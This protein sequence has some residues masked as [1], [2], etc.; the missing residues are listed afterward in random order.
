MT[1][2]L[3]VQQV[4][5]ALHD[6]LCRYIEA[7][8][9]VRDT[10]VIEERRALLR[11]QGTI[12]QRPY[13]ETT[14]SYEL[15]SSYEQLDLPAPVG[16]W[17]AE[18]ASWSPAIGVFARPFKHQAEAL[19]AALRD[20]RDLVVATGTGS[21]KTE[22]FLHTILG[23]LVL[24]GAHRTASWARPGVRALLLYPMNA[25]VSD[26]LTR[27]RRLFGDERLAAVFRERTGR[28]PRF[29]M[30][31]SRTPY[32]GVRTSE[33]DR[34]LVAPV[35][36]YYRDLLHGKPL[37]SGEDQVA[38]ET[39]A[40]E[41]HQRG[42]WPAK[43]ID[44]FLGKAGGR[45]EDRLVTHPDDRELLTRHEQHKETP[46]LLITNHSMLEYML[47]RPIERSLFRQTRAWLA[48][49]RAAKLNVVLDEAHLYRGVA[50]AEIGLLLRRLFARLE[51]PRSRVRVILT[52]ASLGDRPEDRAAIERFAREL[53]G[54]P[55]D[56]PTPFVQVSSSAVPR[57]MARVGTSAEAAAF[58]RLDLSGFFQHATSLDAAASAV[59][60]VAA[61]LGWPPPP[62]PRATMT[63][64]AD[65]SLRGYLF[66]HLERT[67][68]LQQLLTLTAGHARPFDGLG[69]LCFPGVDLDVGLRAVTAMVALGTYAHDGKRPLMPARA[70]CFF[71]GLP[72][73]H[74]CIDP[75]CGQRRHQPRDGRPSAVGRLYTEPRTHCDCRSRARVYELYAHRDCGALF[76]RVFG[77]GPTPDFYW[78][79]RGGVVERHAAPFDEHL[80]LLDDPHHRL[81]AL[82]EPIWLELPTG[83]VRLTPPSTEQADLYRQVWRARSGVP[84][85]LLRIERRDLQQR[86]GRPGERGT[87]ALVR[88]P[89]CTRQT[90]YKILDL[91]TKGEQPFANVVRTQL[92]LQPLVRAIDAAYP[93]GGRKVLLFSDGR[94]K[95]ARLARDLPREVEFDS[96][97]QALALATRR[98]TSL[99][100][101]PTLGDALY[102]AFVSVCADNLLYFFDQEDNSQRHLL[103]DIAAYRARY[104]GDLAILLEE[105]EGVTPPGRFRQAVLR[106][107]ADPYYS[108][109]AACCAIVEPSAAASRALGRELVTGSAA[110]TKE[111]IDALLSPSVT[112]W[113]QWLLDRGAFDPAISEAARFAVNPYFFAVDR[114]HRAQDVERILEAHGRLSPNQIGHWREASY[115]ILTREDEAGHP[116]LTPAQLTLR[117]AI[118]E[119]W[120]QCLTCGLTQHTTL[121]GRCMECGADTL[122]PRQ[123]D[124]AYMT[125]RHDYIRLPLRAVLNGARPL[126]MTA[127]EH[128]AQLSQRDGGEVY[129][130][131]EAYELRF[132]DV[133]LDATTP[134]VDVLSCTTTM[135]VGIDIGSLTAVG[136]RNVPPQREHYQQRA[137]RSGRRGS[138]VSTVVTYADDSA[139]D[140]FYYANPAPMI[141][142]P[143]RA[144]TLE[145]ANPRLA[146]R[147]VHAFLIQTF[148]HETLDRLGQVDEAHI[149]AERATLMSALGETRPFLDGRDDFS[150]PAFEA[151][152]ATMIG[153]GADGP[154][155]PVLLT[156]LPD[157]MC[158]GPAAEVVAAEK[159]QFIA[160]TTTGLLEAL[161]SRAARLPALPP[162]PPEGQ[163]PLEDPA[164]LLLDHLFDAGVLPTYAFPTN[165]ATFWIYGRD[166]GRLVV[167]EAPQQDKH[168]AL[169]EYAPG[170]LLV[171]DKKSYRVGGLAAPDLLALEPGGALLGAD[172]PAYVWCPVCT[173]VDVRADCQRPLEPCPVCR[174]GLSQ[175]TLVD[176]PG[177]Y[178]EG[179]RPLRE[180]DSAQAISVASEAQLPAPTH[181]MQLAWE[182]GP[183]RNLQVAIAP[184]QELVLANKGPGEQGFALCERCGAIWPEPD[185]P[186]L[187]RHRRPH[188]L[189]YLHRQA[190][191]DH[192]CDGPLA[193]DPIFL[194]FRFR[195][196]CL[197]LQAP[198]RPP[199]GYVPGGEPWLRDAA[200]TV[201]QALALAA[202]R[203][204]DV[205][206]RELA[207]GVRFVQPLPTMPADAR[208]AI[209]WFLYDTASGGAGY[210]A[211][212]GAVL[213]EVLNAAELLL[214]SC[215][216]DC[217]RSCT[218]CLRHYGNRFW[219]E[220]LDRHIAGQLLA[221]VRRDKA[222]EIESAER[223]AERLA[224]LNQYLTLEGWQVR[225]CIETAGLVVPLRA[226]RNGT[227]VLIGTLPALLDP[228]T[229]RE[230]HPAR[231][232]ARDSGAMDVLLCDYV[233]ARDL[234]TAAQNL[235]RRVQ[236]PV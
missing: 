201:A 30:Y 210:A 37:E 118:D 73:L 179:G 3:G 66:Q 93:N 188:P 57:P 197:L 185:R 71:R 206:P 70:H 43:D 121:A 115:R 170:R 176:P 205:D 119:P 117:L 92:G 100:R 16:A 217:D 223:Q 145:V 78:H 49:D 234:P 184:N 127:E 139:H 90:G 129:A 106:Q 99:G 146:R 148:F 7:Q 85:S 20:G 233:V 109:Y 88:C 228:A 54:V 193:Q 134:P 136:C 163:S 89:H 167:Q 232:A 175:R 79:E 171:V 173:Y 160:T 58:A 61:D 225:D 42:R 182:R 41:L 209:E 108:L 8:Y 94:Q 126:H 45:W 104:D 111:Q 77:R 159:R 103:Q 198:L 164:G 133:R 35:I 113:I 216:G 120:I 125:A 91:A 219:H 72:S 144:P 215:P 48:A 25:L 96:F 11:A 169:S 74:A 207:A 151:W 95:A 131:T 44:G 192:W 53:S 203:A 10:E 105:G 56:V 218:R 154:L 64:A 98:L 5:D 59:A 135:E 38:R 235:Y 211:E 47:L 155:T 213:G 132:Q 142:G 196:D 80:L 116:Y 130:T 149:A 141:S 84:D 229:A 29:G 168:I 183:E 36:E 190:G 33:K 180:R 60:A 86:M 28:H 123:P 75:R 52:S 231:L 220:R 199:L 50:G 76:L 87:G 122:V 40:R 12:A 236:S 195:T 114:G 224:P 214:K 13:L 17:L 200:R 140:N 4:A 152:C 128:T 9:H 27:L 32:A 212:C 187:L 166:Q 51:V 107:L 97:R 194:G 39:L 165:V 138:A 1:T 157:A 22:V 68:P 172:P 221:A 189:T 62:V 153:R 81:R 226:E 6:S 161:R 15:G 24:E 26:Q 63:E 102:R 230:T 46:D 21:G 147:H 69:P 191:I 112:A 178:P 174:T 227:I 156:W 83:R 137:G 124:D 181:T 222:P 186:D 202:T 65:A 2:E 14:P 162:P 67:G 143:P 204:L 208:A 34:R 177:F 31:T 150:L 19:Q 82:V 101:P 18:L 158:S 55:D 23:D 110:W